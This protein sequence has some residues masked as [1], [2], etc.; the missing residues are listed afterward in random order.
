M[1]CKTGFLF[2]RASPGHTTNQ[3]KSLSTQGA[4]VLCPCDIAHGGA[5]SGRYTSTSIL[6]RGIDQTG[7]WI[8]VSGM[9]CWVGQWE[10]GRAVYWDGDV[11]GGARAHV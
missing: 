9:W 5:P 1:R 2:S 7:F 6:T 3:K 4:N 10:G 8:N 11:L